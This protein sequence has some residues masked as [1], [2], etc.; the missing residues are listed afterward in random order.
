MQTTA[1][2]PGTFDPITLGHSDLVCRAARLF[3]RVIVAVAPNAS[4]QAVFSLDERLAMARAVDS[5]AEVNPYRQAIDLGAN[6]VLVGNFTVVDG[7]DIL[8][9]A[10]MIDAETQQVLATAEAI[11]SDV[12]IPSRSGW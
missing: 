6:V 8:L 5:T 4:K 12:E 1:I 2:Y 7:E 9:M 3:A 11:V 10:R